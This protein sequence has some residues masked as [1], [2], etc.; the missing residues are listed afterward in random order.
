MGTQKNRLNETQLWSI[1]PSLVSDFIWD[2]GKLPSPAHL[3][4]YII[5]NGK[6][7]TRIHEIEKIKTIF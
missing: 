4:K 5:K 2:F 6:I 3:G 7:S 1:Y